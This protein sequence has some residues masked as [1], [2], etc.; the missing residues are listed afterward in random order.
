MA[1]RSSARRGRATVPGFQELRDHDLAN[2]EFRP[3]YVIDGEDDL[4]IEQT[5]DAI[6]ERALEP[7]AAAFNEHVLAA[8]EVGWGAVL[9]QAQAYP[10][11]G[12]RQLVIARRADALP[13]TKDDPGVQAIARYLA[14]PVATTILV[15]VGEHFHGNAGWVRAAKDAGYY[16][17]FA[18]PSGR[19]LDAWV[20]RA[21][22]KQGLDLAP[23]ARRVLCELVG[24][25]LRALQADL[26][27]LGLLQESRG[28]PV[29]AEELPE[30]VMDQADL[31]VF[32]VTD[33]IAAGDAARAMRAWQ[34]LQ[35]WGRDAYEL[36][37]L[38]I[39]H[40]RR[41]VAVAAALGDGKRIDE[42]ASETGLNP[43]MVRNKIKPQAE[44]L[45]RSACTR[46][47][48]TCLAC[49][50]AQKSRPVPPELAFEQLL[51]ATATSTP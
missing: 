17:H 14:D 7:A 32:E 25:D 2:G 50:R 28:R 3:V 42:V 11:L 38:V 43:W 4:R 19:D 20:E 23:A 8:D 40:L 51:L 10:M 22:H 39:A 46:L 48:D 29:T 12:G 31:E 45:D 16:F 1:A 21:A 49:E 24:S 30:L 36:T 26:E 44:S 27:K 47:L 6:K 9:Q 33:A 41:T 15:L 18:P 13:W 5:I 34:R 35:T 37:P